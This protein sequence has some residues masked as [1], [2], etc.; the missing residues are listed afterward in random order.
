V[1]LK[2]GET[3]KSEVVCKVLDCDTI[4]QTKDKAL[5]A[6]YTNTPYTQRP[7]AH[8]VQLCAY[9]LSPVVVVKR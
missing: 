1:K 3:V 8:D 5:D 4:S 9:W 7:A 6:L 2:V